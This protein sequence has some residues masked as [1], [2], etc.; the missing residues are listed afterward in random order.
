MQEEESYEYSKVK[1]DL[2]G[3]HWIAVRPIDT[4]KLECPNCGNVSYFENIPYDDYS[5]SG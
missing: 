5:N 4:P 1:C 3:Y 2:C